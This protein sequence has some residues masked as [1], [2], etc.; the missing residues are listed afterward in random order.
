MLRFEL[1]TK[2]T[3][4]FVWTKIAPL[5]VLTACAHQQ[6]AVEVRTVEVAVPRACVPADQIPAEPETVADQLTGQAGADTLILA[7]S[8]LQLRAWGRE[9]AALLRACG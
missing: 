3:R 9:L 7:E 5:F 4:I 1:G 8:A 6:P 2:Y